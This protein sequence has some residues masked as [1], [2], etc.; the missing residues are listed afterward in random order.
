MH[1]GN[2]M[3]PCGACIGAFFYFDLFVSQTNRHVQAAE[4]RCYL[5]KCILQFSCEKGSPV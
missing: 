2:Q 3:Y 1:R 5:D 4:P